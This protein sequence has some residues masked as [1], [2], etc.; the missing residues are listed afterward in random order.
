MP[1]HVTTYGVSS[2]ESQGQT[3]TVFQPPPPPPPIQTQTVVQRSP[4]VGSNSGSG[5]VSLQGPPPP[6]SMN[7]PQSAPEGGE[8]VVERYKQGS[9]Y[10]G[11]KW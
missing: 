6:P 5:Q 9:E 3:N 7:V 1:A 11:Y 4:L 8:Y 2:F 10:K